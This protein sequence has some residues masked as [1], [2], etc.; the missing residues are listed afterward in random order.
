MEGNDRKR[1]KKEGKDEDHDPEM[2]WKQMENTPFYSLLV[3]TDWSKTSLGPLDTWPDAFRTNVILCFTSKF[4][5]S[6]F[7]GKD[8]IQVYNESYVGLV[9]AKHPKIWATPLSEGFS[10]VWK[11]L[12][13]MINGVVESGEGIFLKDHLFLLESGDIL[14]EGYY[15]FSYSPIVQDRHIVGIVDTVASS[16]H[17]INGRRMELLRNVALK[18]GSIKSESEI[19]PLLSDLFKGNTYDISFHSLYL[20]KEGS[21][22]LSCSS[23]FDEISFP[24]LIKKENSSSPFESTFIDDVLKCVEEMN[25]VQMDLK[26]YSFPACGHWNSPVNSCCMTPLLSGENNVIGVLVVGINQHLHF[27][28]KYQ[29]FVKVLGNQISSFVTTFKLREENLKRM[30]ELQRL[31]R[32]RTNF[33]TTVPHEFRTPVTLTLGPLECLLNKEK[34][35]FSEDQYKRVEV[36][37]RNALKVMKL[38]NDILDFHEL[39]DGKMVPKYEPLDITSITIE[40]CSLFTPSCEKENLNLRVKCD[41]IKEKPFVDKEMWEKIVYNLLSNAMK[42]TN[43][44]GS[45]EVNLYEDEDNVYFK[46]SDT[47]IGISEKD[48]PFVGQRFFRANEGGVVGTGIGLSLVSELA[49]FHGG[50]LRVESELNKGTTITVHIKKGTAHLIESKKEESSKLRTISSENPTRR[51]LTSLAKSKLR[52]SSESLSSFDQ[53]GS[54]ILCL[55]HDSNIQEH[56]SAA[57]NHEY[58]L[59][60]TPDIP[61]TLKRLY[62][63]IPDLVLVDISSH[64]EDGFSLIESMKKDESLVN[65]PIIFI[66]TRSG[67]HKI[68]SLDRGVDDCLVMPFTELELKARIST[69]I[70]NAKNQIQSKNHHKDLRQVAE[71]ATI[72][73]DNFLAMLAHEMR[74]P[75]APAL[76]LVEEMISE[77]VVPESVL[78]KIKLIHQTI[79]S[80]VL[81]ID[82]LLD[83]V[84]ISKSKLALFISAVDLHNCI[85][86]SAEKV[87]NDLKDSGMELIWSL[88]AKNSIVNGDE[89]RLNQ[90]LW[91]VLKNAIKFGRNGKKIKIISRNPKDNPNTI[92]VE[93]VDYG[94]GLKDKQLKTIFDPMEMYE[95]NPYKTTGLGVGLHITQHIVEAHGGSVNAFSDGIDKGATVRLT[96]PVIEENDAHFD[97]SNL[98]NLSNNEIKKV[99]VDT[100]PLSI[101][102]VE[103]N[104][105]IRMVLTRVLNK[106]NHK[107]KAV[108]MASQAVESARTLIFD[109]FISDIGLPDGNGYDLVRMV[110]QVALQPHKSI[111]LSGFSLPEDI[112]ASID[113][114][115]DIHLTKPIQTT[116]LRDS[117]HQLCVS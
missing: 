75:L 27:D 102:L 84:K 58:E 68:E 112:Q 89:S 26:P 80:E 9:P 29:G 83:M 62:T 77:K 13:V 99:V 115:F 107:V 94:V 33:Y 31:D 117:I 41:D 116:L 10:E 36:I 61:E 1:R 76:M 78:K 91:N 73:K 30:N 81:L 113:A 96:F 45:I 11:E 37:Y 18:T 2:W 42:F 57:L 105:A 59:R 5:M 103:D 38:V 60:F 101:L 79:Q 43:R 67:D 7:L 71:F 100:K 86:I 48:L 21:F 35:Q 22:Q 110:R 19:P 54:K 108:G 28:Q 23:N 34:D 39:E 90:I 64:P 72:A 88:D 92:E 16:S 20:K 15:N 56:L 53:N 63:D 40:N 95:K 14:E 46:V 82:N 51:W 17:V 49:K 87:K 70:Q 98:Q 74:T 106:M 12:S 52:T 3:S 50:D 69:H 24:T 8:L 104:E 85:K 6:L 55:F 4:P 47:G 111:A 25:L 66:N 109:L 97:R 44:G 114:G 65:V 93:I 32:N